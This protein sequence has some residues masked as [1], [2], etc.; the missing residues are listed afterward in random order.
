M[1]VFGDGRQTHLDVL[2]DIVASMMGL[3]WSIG[4]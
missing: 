2:F 4:T 3:E 1:A